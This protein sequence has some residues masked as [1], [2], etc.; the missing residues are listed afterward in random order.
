L[1]ILGRIKNHFKKGEEL[2]LSEYLDERLVT[3][4]DEKSQMDA[5]Q[6]LVDLL[7]KEGRLKDKDAFFEAILKREKIVST[8]IGIGVAIPHAKLAGYDD[9][10][11]AIG[12]QK[13]EGI[14]WNAL[15]DLPVRIIF[16]I[17][18]PEGSQ[19]EYL[20]ILSMIT[21]AMK[22]PERRKK[23]LQMKNAEDVIAVFKDL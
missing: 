5:L 18:G 11:I 12:I 16:L 6:T 15:D 9:F 1:V 13:G 21:S 22:D 7:D 10:F 20:N 3:F 14:D 19:T 23:L 8:G 4:L 2:A 17:G